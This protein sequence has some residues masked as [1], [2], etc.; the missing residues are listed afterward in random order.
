MTRSEG[1]HYASLLVDNFDNF[2]N[3]F[4]GPMPPPHDLVDFV[5]LPPGHGRGVTDF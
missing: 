3:F 1:Y 2:D 5:V 4:F